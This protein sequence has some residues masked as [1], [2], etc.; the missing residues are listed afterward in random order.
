MA[1]AG[2]LRAL[3]VKVTGSPSSRTSLLQ[4]APHSEL[5]KLY[6]MQEPPLLAFSLLSIGRRGVKRR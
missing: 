1:L 5:L 3:F 6:G 2:S 4:V